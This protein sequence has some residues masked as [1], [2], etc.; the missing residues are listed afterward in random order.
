[1]ISSLLLGYKMVVTHPLIILEYPW[2][3]EGDVSCP[4]GFE[5]WS[6]DLQ[7]PH[8]R[9]V[10]YKLPWCVFVMCSLFIYLLLLFIIIY[11]LNKQHNS[12]SLNIICMCFLM[13]SYMHY[14][15]ANCRYNNLSICHT[16][17]DVEHF[18]LS[19]V[20]YSLYAIYIVWYSEP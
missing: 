14:I 7:W 3:A 6:F 4:F 13:H 10:N 19:F 17:I 18:C 2:F 15:F 9:S 5:K 16:F 1:M 20:V 12:Q 11:V 8:I